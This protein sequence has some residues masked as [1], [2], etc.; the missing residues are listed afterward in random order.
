[1]NVKQRLA[2]A[3]IVLTVAAIVAAALLSSD[4]DERFVERIHQKE[5]RERLEVA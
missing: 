5:G 3:G 1:M 2:L 4:Q